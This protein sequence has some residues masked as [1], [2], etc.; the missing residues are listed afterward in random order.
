MVNISVAKTI[1][2]ATFRSEMKNFCSKRFLSLVR[3]R[4]FCPFMRKWET[5]I[6]RISWIEILEYCFNSREISRLLKAK[7]QVNSFKRFL[8]LFASP[9]YR[10]SFTW[11][12]IHQ[13]QST[14]F[15]S[16]A[17]TDFLFFSSGDVYFI[18]D[19]IPSWSFVICFEIAMENDW[20]QTRSCMNYFRDLLYLLFGIS[21][22]IFLYHKR[23]FAFLHS[24]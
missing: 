24:V 13:D 4:T 16:S 17:L 19:I 2:S 12:F 7:N 20:F 11:T 3:I 8:C 1:I 9:S 22:V 15:T 5:P 10:M 18:K 21:Q 14:R 6:N 23:A